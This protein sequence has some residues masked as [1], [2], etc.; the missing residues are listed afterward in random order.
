MTRTVP[1]ALLTQ[2]LVVLWYTQHG[3]HHSTITQRRVEAPWY[4]QKTQPAYHD[5][6]IKKK[7]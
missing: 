4:R 2:T 1:F 7:K 3:H 6:I 5:M